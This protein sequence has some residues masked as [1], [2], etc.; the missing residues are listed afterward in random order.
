MGGEYLP[1]KRRECIPT[2]GVEY[3]STREEYVPTRRGEIAPTSIGEYL[4]TTGEKVYI[5]CLLFY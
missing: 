4:L 2:M 5:L 1:N 3:V